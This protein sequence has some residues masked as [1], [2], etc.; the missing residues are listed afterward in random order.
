MSSHKKQRTSHPCLYSSLVLLAIA[1]FVAVLLLSVNGLFITY[2]VFLPPLPS[3][4][5]D[6]D[7]CAQYLRGVEYIIKALDNQIGHIDTP[8]YIFGT[9]IVVLVLFFLDVVDDFICI[10]YRILSEPEHRFCAASVTTRQTTIKKFKLFNMSCES[11]ESLFSIFCN[12]FFAIVCIMWVF[13]NRLDSNNDSAMRCNRLIDLIQMFVLAFPLC[14]TRCDFARKLSLRI[15]CADN[16]PL[17]DKFAL[18]ST[19][20]SVGHK[21]KLLNNMKESSD[22]LLLFHT[23]FSNPWNIVVVLVV[24]FGYILKAMEKYRSWSLIDNL[25]MNT[26]LFP[27]LFANDLCQCTIS[28]PCPLWHLFF[29]EFFFV[30]A[31]LY[32]RRVYRHWDGIRTQQCF[33][34]TFSQTEKKGKL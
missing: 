31:V 5:D 1:T 16:V 22:S 26:P 15:R 33:L 4:L 11:C 9:P 6:G 20:T 24:L 17:Q 34:A 3:Q 18:K 32:I 25:F 28:S 10:W 29:A 23:I 30:S 14:T 13:C 27:A 7:N 8:W 2:I 19:T 12:A 21:N